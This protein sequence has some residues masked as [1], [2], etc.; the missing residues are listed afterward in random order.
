[1]SKSYAELQEMIK[2]VKSNMDHQKE[3]IEFKLK[4]LQELTYFL[5]HAKENGIAD[6][7][8]TERIKGWKAYK[9]LEPVKIQRMLARVH[10]AFTSARDKTIELDLCQACE[11]LYKNIQQACENMNQTITSIE[12]LILT[13]QS[14]ENSQNNI[15]K[16]DSTIKQAEITF[17]A[18]FNEILEAMKKIEEHL[19]IFKKIVENVEEMVAREMWRRHLEKTKIQPTEVKE[20]E[21]KPPVKFIAD[22]AALDHQFYSSPRKPKQSKKE[23]YINALRI[24]ADDKENPSSQ[25]IALANYLFESAGHHLLA[26]EKRYWPLCIFSIKTKSMAT[27]Q[28]LLAH[29]LS[30]QDKKQLL[31][32]E[33]YMKRKQ[34]LEAYHEEMGFCAKKLQK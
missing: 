25:K 12:Q 22:P 30:D 8:L 10:Q 18:N 26:K 1:M 7:I 17:Q 15:L 19:I 5:I 3:E 23:V 29:G 21:I 32:N 2:T 20:I 14:E 11:N 24:W 16:L 33:N 4:H 31:F 27:A 9:E 28:G 13:F 34:A 6:V